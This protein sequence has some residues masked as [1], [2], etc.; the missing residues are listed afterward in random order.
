MSRLYLVKNLAF[1]SDI[2]K[3][4]DVLESGLDGSKVG[5][6]DIIAVESLYNENN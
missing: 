2:V 1:G 5:T 3:Y 4:V 6:T